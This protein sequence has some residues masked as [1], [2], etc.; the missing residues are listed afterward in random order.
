M[1]SKSNEERPLG[2]RLSEI[3]RKGVREVEIEIIVCTHADLTNSSNLVDILAGNGHSYC[4]PERCVEDCE[5]MGYCEREYESDT[6]SEKAGLRQCRQWKLR[7][8]VT[9]VKVIMTRRSGEK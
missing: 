4:C 7:V 1:R 2:W 8:S 9:P 3:D 6:G 5:V